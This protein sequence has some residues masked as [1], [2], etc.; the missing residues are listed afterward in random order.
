MTT[1]EHRLAEFSSGK[2]EDGLPVELLC[3]D[4]AG[5]YT[6]PF[7]CR[8]TVGAWYNAATGAFID[9]RVV[10]WRRF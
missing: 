4:H 10:G 6:L 8:W 1:R 7:P 5:T 9:A 3:E 2:P